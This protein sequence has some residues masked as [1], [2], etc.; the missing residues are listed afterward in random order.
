MSLASIIANPFDGVKLVAGFA[1]TYPNVKIGGL[2]QP[3]AWPDTIY[4][5]V[6]EPVIIAQSV[7]DNSITHNVVVARVGQPGPRDA[8][9]Q[10]VP[11]GSDTITV[12]DV[13]G[14]PYT[15]TFGYPSPTVGDSVRL[16]WQGRD[17]TAIC[18]VGVTPPSSAGGGATTPPPAPA[19]FG[20]FPG[21]AT[22]SGTWTPAFN[23]W[24]NWG[25]GG[26]Y[27][28][29]G[30]APYGA[31]NYG[32][33]FYNGVFAELAGANYSRVQVRIP[34]RKTVGNYNA[35]QTLHIYVHNSPTRPGGDV[36]RVLGPYDVYVPANFGG[37]YTDIDPAAAPVLVAG[38][39]IS[40][41]G[42]PY[43]GFLGKPQDG[44]SG[45]IL[46]DWSR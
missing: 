40:I 39:G 22:D 14:V 37:G 11:G 26:G 9:V 3:A 33:W 17:G 2:S 6:G 44:A 29:Q 42:E 16:L 45:Q 46:I 27:V 7:K 43:M 4:A 23:A 5:A 8:T 32:A 30:G 24:D 36:N 34:A 20:Q 21:V 41:A 12:T 28:Y 31:A 38:G 25:G 15:V 18:K 10:T 19:S 1:D 13:N 35:G